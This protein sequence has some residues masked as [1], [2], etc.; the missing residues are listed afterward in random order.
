VT[1]DWARRI[2]VERAGG[3]CELCPAVGSEWSHRVARGRGGMWAPSNGLWLCHGCHAK[4]HAQPDTARAHGWHLSTGTDP[5]EAPAYITPGHLWRS[6]WRLDDEG[7][8][9]PVDVIAA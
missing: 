9:L 4:C 1:E 5:L 2:V 8:Y 7:L 6:W 3:R